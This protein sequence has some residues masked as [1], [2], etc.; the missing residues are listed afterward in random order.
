MQL[1]LRRNAKVVQLHPMHYWQ[2]MAIAL[3]TIAL[4]ESNFYFK[5]SLP[6]EKEPVYFFIPVKNAS[7]RT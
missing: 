4:W 1:Q 3:L 6:T 2:N 5:Q 7:H